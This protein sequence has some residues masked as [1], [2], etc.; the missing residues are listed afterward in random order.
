MHLCVPNFSN[1]EIKAIPSAVLLEI[2]DRAKQFLKK[3]K[4]VQKMFKDYDLDVNIIDHIP[5]R[6]DDLDVSA[7]TAYGII[8]LNLKLLKDGDF[9]DDYHYLVHEIEH[10]LQQ[11]YGDK[12]TKGADDGDYLKNPYEL[13]AFQKQLKYIDD[14]YGEEKVDEYADQVLDHHK[15]KDKEERKD[16]KENFLKNLKMVMDMYKSEKGDKHGQ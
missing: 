9:V 14:T 5:V 6:F 2:I 10:Y 12:P 11:N 1:N 4:L 13:D 8:T 15:V 3:K 16:K 7:R